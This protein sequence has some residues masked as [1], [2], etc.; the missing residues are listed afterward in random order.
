MD[1]EPRLICT[2]FPCSPCAVMNESN[3]A[4]SIESSSSMFPYGGPLFRF[5]ADR[6]TQA[7]PITRNDE[8]IATTITNMVSWEALSVW[9][10]GVLV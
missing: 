1:I 5:K 4:C 7:M 10:P 9:V 8:T 6:P 3:S 2:S